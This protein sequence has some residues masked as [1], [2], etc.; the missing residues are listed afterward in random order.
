MSYDPKLGQPGDF[1]F[2]YT[3]RQ[4]A[5]QHILPA[6]Q[7]RLSPALVMRDPLE[8][9][10]ALVSGSW[11]V[12]DDPKAQRAVEATVMQASLDLQQLRR[13]SKV[14]CLTIDA[15][16]YVGDAE[17]F[18]R[19]YARA[20]MW[21]QYAEKHKGVCLMFR[22]GDFEASVLEQLRSRS[23]ESWGHAVTY[24]HRGILEDAAAT[25]LLPSNLRATDLRSDHLR[26][27]LQS[28]FFTKLTD[29]QS[30]HE[31][32][33]VESSW[34]ERR[35]FVDIGDTLA[36]VILGWRFPGWQT[37]GVSPYATDSASIRG[38]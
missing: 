10:P 7:L 32:R 31:Y 9:N 29:W 11:Y 36:G 1:F 2:H 34:N 24:K 20:R 5:F 3:T 13:C 16:D 35:T 18:G 14:L 6:L 22:R 19:G 8:S 21:E 33:F 12:S 17:I 23:P 30:E 27:H 37:P 28:I 25:V 26:K 15:L 4:A 38:K